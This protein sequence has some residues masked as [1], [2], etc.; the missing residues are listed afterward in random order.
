[1]AQ[2]CELTAQRDN[3]VSAYL[4]ARC[5]KVNRL[6][7]RNLRERHVAT[8]KTY[9]P[10]SADLGF[11]LPCRACIGRT[12][13]AIAIQREAIGPLPKSIGS[14]RPFADSAGGPPA[15]KDTEVARGL[16]TLAPITE[17]YRAARASEA[18]F[19]GWRC[20]QGAS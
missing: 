9:A 10:A 8:T 19:E 14:Q 7:S 18:K 5:S 16:D 17:D 11:V 3:I 2:Y 1:M 15:E 4:M 6:P 13:A 12:P 20:V